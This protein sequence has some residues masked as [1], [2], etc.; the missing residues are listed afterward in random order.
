MNPFNFA[1]EGGES[2]PTY[3]Y[4]FNHGVPHDSC[5]QYNSW[6]NVEHGTSCEDDKRH[7]CRQCDGPVPTKLGEE[8]YDNCYTPDDFDLFYVSTYGNTTSADDI[9]LQIAAFGPVSCGF[10]SSVATEEYRGGLFK[11]DLKRD[12]VEDHEVSIVGW[13]HDDE[14]DQ[15]YWI[16]RQDYGTAWGE[17]GFMRI[18]MGDP[19]TNMGI[20]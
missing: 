2:Y 11:A 8:L 3:E 4:I 9:K 6:T 20:E 16:M 1:C 17:M 13:G 5:N 15:D 12:P 14:S 19:R 10:E 7:I 18:V